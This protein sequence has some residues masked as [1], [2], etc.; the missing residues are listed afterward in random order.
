ML[1][2]SEAYIYTYVAFQ[3]SRQ[4]AL[5][6]Q[7]FSGSGMLRNFDTAEACPVLGLNNN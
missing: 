2:Q 7:Y 1:S 3:M 6:V 4:K 5:E